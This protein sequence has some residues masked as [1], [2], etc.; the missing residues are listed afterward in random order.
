[1]KSKDTV[2]VIGYILSKDFGMIFLEIILGIIH[3]WIIS[4]KYYVPMYLKIVLCI[5]FIIVLIYLSIRVN[6]AIKV[7]RE[8]HIPIVV[9]VARSDDETKGNDEVRAVVND[10]LDS[11][12]EYNFDERTFKDD[13]Y[14]NRDDWLVERKSSLPEDSSEWINHVHR[15]RDTIIR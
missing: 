1:M 5:I 8:K 13:F 12:N 9:A 4:T 15:F 6:T 10:V 14:M 7:F 11:M 3:I 2:E